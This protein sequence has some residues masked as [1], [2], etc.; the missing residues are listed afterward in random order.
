VASLWWLRLDVAHVAAAHGDTVL[1][2]RSCDTFDS[3][4]GYVDL[5]VRPESKA[6]C[7]QLRS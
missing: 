7:A 6:F 3:L 5:V 4:I 1:A 2:R